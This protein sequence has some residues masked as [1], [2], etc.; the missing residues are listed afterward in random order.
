MLRHL[1]KLIWN[2]KGTHSLLIIEIWASFMVLFGV[3]SLIV[4]NVSNYMEPIGFEYES[5]WNLDLDNNQ[6]TTKVAAKLQRIMQH[7][8][9][10]PE[11]ESVSRMSSNTPFSAN[12]MNN[13]VTYNKV[14]VLTDQYRTD[15]NF[16]TTL[17]LPLAAGRWYKKEDKV[18]KSIPI[19]IN[20]KMKE[21]LFESE[22]PLGRIIKKDDKTSFKV[23]GVIDNF[24]AKGEFM[25]NDP[26]MFEVLTDDNDWDSNFLMRVKPGTDADFEAKLVKDVAV[27]L[28]GWGIEVSYLKESRENRHKLTL[29]P[30]IIFL[31]VSGFLLTNVALGLFGILNLSIARRRGEIGLRRAMGATEGKVAIQFLGEIWVL[32]AFSMI[33]GLVFAA[34]FPIMNVFDIASGIYVTAIIAASIIIFLIVTLCAWY[35]SR[36]ASRIHPAVALHEE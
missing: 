24:K 2:K 25:A 34:Q 16:S 31:I 22:N 18:A 8:K 15:E 20:G 7:V 4:Y 36:Q 26:A 3:L 23:I 13:S 35:P 28:P 5:V 19:V 11:V 30:V 17:S 14:S 27:M 33:I 1:F 12:Q 9:A 21:K 32:A 6:D 10:Y 29:V